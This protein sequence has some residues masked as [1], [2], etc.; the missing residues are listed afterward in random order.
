MPLWAVWK[1]NAE[2]RKVPHNPVTGRP[3]KSNDAATF[4]TRAKSERALSTGKYEGVCVLVD[5]SLGITMLDFDHIVPEEHAGDETQLPPDVRRIVRMANTYTTWSP[6][7]TGIRMF[8]AATTGRDYENKNHGRKVCIA[9]QYNSVR[10]ATI[11]TNAPIS[12]TPE[13]FNDNRDDLMAVLDAL[14]FKPRAASPPPLPRPSYVGGSHTN[15]EIIETASRVNGE[16]FRRLHSGDI[17]GYPESASDK[18]FSS[19]ADAALA[20]IICGYT[21]H[22]DQVADIMNGSGLS[23]GKF[24]RADY[25][26]RTIESARAKQSWWYEWDRPKGTPAAT[27]NDHDGYSA[28]P[29]TATTDERLDHALAK[30]ARQAKI[31]RQQRETLQGIER[32]LANDQIQI[33]PR[34]TGIALLLELNSQEQRG[35]KPKE[36]GHHIPAVWLAR[37]TGSTAKTANSHVKKLEEMD[38]IQRK[39]VSEVI[40]E[41]AEDEVVDEDSGEIFG[42]IRKRA[43]YTAGQAS[44]IISNLAEYR[45]V[46]G[47]TRHGGK[48]IA[49]C[50]DHPN[51]GTVKRWTIECAE[52]H[53]PLDDGVF[54]RKADGLEDNPHP[55]T[56][57]GYS[58]DCDDQAAPNTPRI[59]KMG[60]HSADVVIDIPKLG[61]RGAP[62]RSAPPPKPD[63]P[64]E[65][66]I[67]PPGEAG[68]DRHTA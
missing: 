3:A 29:A 62:G 55:S 63:A 65:G 23:R 15:N 52:C 24:N 25:L 19:E 57:D 36:H 21:E 37:R 30:I 31:I 67:P 8:C 32:I 27:P 58:G 47:D 12:N 40:A 45:R 10:F 16:K 64:P 44:A 46:D 1:R 4:S 28:P 56:H 49:A 20:M 11:M 17:A 41:D 22:D 18:G 59:P 39:V 7:R 13:G 14:D 2:G 9:E 43:Y 66:W 51:A 61:I 5:E 54:Y 26:P 38:L 48:R 35:K 53:K 34:V 42:T 6:S 60:I 33:G 50:K 68:H